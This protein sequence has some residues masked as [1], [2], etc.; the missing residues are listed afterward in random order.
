MT[1]SLVIAPNCGRSWRRSTRACRRCTGR[2]RL[3]AAFA[4]RRR[5]NRANRRWKSKACAPGRRSLRSYCGRWARARRG[6]GGGAPEQN[7]QRLKNELQAKTQALS[8]AETAFNQHKQEALSAKKSAEVA[9]QKFTQ[10]LQARQQQL[11]EAQ[12]ALKTLSMKSETDAAAARKVAEDLKAAQTEA[13]ECKRRLT[14]MQGLATTKE[15]E[16]AAR[17]SEMENFQRDA[18]ALQKRA[19]ED[20]AKLLADSQ[21]REKAWAEAQ[22]AA[23]AKRGTSFPKRPKDWGGK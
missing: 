3:R 16:A 22:A 21:A 4:S 6:G 10:D 12:A 9:I 20:R 19:E 17:K 23:Q 18:L 2:W 15:Q 14:E 5:K 13:T 1:G 11:D 8:Q 7:V